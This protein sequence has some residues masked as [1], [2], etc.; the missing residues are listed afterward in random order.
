MLPFHEQGSH[1]KLIVT[2]YPTG[3]TELAGVI[4]VMAARSKIK[5]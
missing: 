1:Q 4:E 3:N 2:M 5:E